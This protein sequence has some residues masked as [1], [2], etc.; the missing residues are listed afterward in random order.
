V[1]ILAKYRPEYGEKKS[2]VLISI[3]FISDE[4]ISMNL[5]V[6]QVTQMDRNKNI[7]VL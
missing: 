3:S 4:F 7:F 5:S 2:G 1:Y 6:I